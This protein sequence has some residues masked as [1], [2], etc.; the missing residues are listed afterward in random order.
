MGYV[1]IAEL[2]YEMTKLNEKMG[3]D[4]IEELIKEIDIFGDGTVKYNDWVE[5]AMK[6]LKS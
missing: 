3:L 2:R 4:E 6:I 1:P 5:S